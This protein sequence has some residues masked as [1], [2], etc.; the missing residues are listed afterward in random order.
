MSNQKNYLL[1]VIALSCAAALTLSACSGQDSNDDGQTAAT[2]TVTETATT[3]DAQ[4]SVQETWVDLNNSVVLVR[5]GEHLTAFSTRYQTGPNACNIVEK[6]HAGENVK[7]TRENGFNKFASG[8]LINYQ[9]EVMWERTVGGPRRGYRPA[10]ISIGS[11]TITMPD[12][13]SATNPNRPPSPLTF[14][15]ADSTIGEKRLA[16]ICDQQ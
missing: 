10:T 8:D 13:F 15:K 16:E 11:D 5:N 1:R 2:S 12:I 14:V 6:L 4:E 9:S 7:G 3:Q